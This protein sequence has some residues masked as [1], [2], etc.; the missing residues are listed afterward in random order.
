MFN[1]HKRNRVQFK[2]KGESLTKQ[3]MKN[4][5]DINNIMRRYEKT[6]FISHIKNGGTYGDFSTVDSYHSAMNEIIAAKE[7]FM[8]LPAS[9]RKKFQ[10]DPA[11]MIEFLQN[12]E[13]YDEAV[14]LGLIEPKDKKKP[15]TIVPPP[16]DPKKASKKPAEPKKPADPAN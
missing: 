9:V 16:E 15:A 13:N 1:A 7:A 4:D 10:N 6:G 11:E 8:T 5:C 14:K 2:T 3:S 12:K